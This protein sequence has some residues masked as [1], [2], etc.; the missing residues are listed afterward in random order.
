M[1]K[2][3]D[4]I[5]IVFNGL[6]M[7]GAEKFGIS[8]ANKFVENGN[9]TSIILFK[10]MDSPLLEQ[11]NSNI[12]IIYINRTSKY[13]FIL[14]KP[15]NKALQANGI[16]KVII[17]GLLPLFLSRVFS[18]KK[19]S[20]IQFFLS[21][22]STIPAS[23]KIFIENFIFLRFAKQTDKVLFICKNQQQFYNTRYKFNPVLNDVIYNGVDVNYFK[24]GVKNPSVDIKEKLQLKPTDKVVVLVATIRKEKGHTYAIEALKYLHTNFPNKLNTHLIFIG[25]GDSAYLEELDE[26]VSDKQLQQFVHFEGNQKDVRDYYSIADIFTLTSFS[27]ETFSIAAL[28]AMSFG[29][30][31]SLTNIGGASEM[32]MEHKN[33]LL[34][35][36]KNS[37]SI[38]T[39]WAKLLDAN[40]NKQSIR[41]IAVANF[42]LPT[43]FAKYQAT[44]FNQTN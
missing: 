20:H 33:G 9:E 17:I 28:E 1:N 10:K 43:M 26:L 32:V 35:E 38:A 22:H 23:F 41:D 13:N 18:F 27:V 37:V 25:G 40:L 44:I 21:L 7:G 3:S 6:F 42:S 16:N 31:L 39:T 34:S 24:Q 8:L 12:N 29:L 5:A 14:H 36:A 30:P 11:I 2:P 19:N 15:F 4:N